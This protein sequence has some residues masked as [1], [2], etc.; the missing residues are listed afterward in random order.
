MAFKTT[1]CNVIVDLYYDMTTKRGREL[2][3]SGG[4]FSRGSTIDSITQ[5][6]E[7]K[8]AY[9]YVVIWRNN[10]FEHMDVYYLKEI[11]YLKHTAREKI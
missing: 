9:K 10:K 5:N 7:S 2:V 11:D 3:H 6:E 1:L 8:I 4:P